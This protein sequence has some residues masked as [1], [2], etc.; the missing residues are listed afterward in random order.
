MKRLILLALV[1]VVEMHHEP[2]QVVFEWKTFDFQWPSDEERRHA[3]ALGDYIAENN[4]FTTVKFWKDRMYLAMPRWKDGTPVTLG[5][6]SAKPVNGVT[7]PKLEPF[8]SWAMQK[9]GDCYAFQLVHSMEID[10]KGR[11]WAL[12]TGRPNFGNL[13]FGCPPRLVIL[14]LENAGEILRTYEFP[15]HV[16]R[17][18][19]A[20]LNDVVLD[21]EDGMIAYITD[22]SEEDYGIIVYSLKNN[23]SWKIR[24]E[25]SM[26]PEPEA[27]RFRVG[28]EYMTSPVPVD[29]IA[30]SP[31]SS[32]DR[33]VYYT[34]L[35]SFHLYSIPVS[36]LKNNTANIDSYV[37]NLGRRVSQTD[38]MIISAKNVL[39]FGLL[40]DN[41]ISRWDIKNSPSFITGQC[42]TWNHIL[43]QWPDSFAF[44]E[45]GNLWC[46]VNKLLNFQNNHVDVNSTNYYL[47]R[48]HEGVRSY[49]Y[50]ENGTAPE[51]PD[52][53][54]E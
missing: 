25:S 11:M 28:N 30:L 8:P 6:T 32:S 1:V 46:V 16:A 54:N 10:P 40:P 2:F 52:I 42:L 22:S 4:F 17:R 43:V 45:S 36:V 12:D 7:A 15:D 53:T 5:V 35:S 26:M 47:I 23:T 14:D 31:A 9:L 48:A 18:G 34:P 39:Y 41:A 37:S 44:D 50:Y 27:V 21:H 3:L 49:Q 29:G 20:Y 38:G 33:Q 13:S 19:V 24:H 51:L